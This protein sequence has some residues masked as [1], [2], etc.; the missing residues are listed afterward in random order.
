MAL[1]ASQDQLIAIHEANSIARLAAEVF[2]LIES[3]VV[4]SLV[5]VALRPLE[6]ELPCLSSKPEYKA[7]LDHYIEED[8]VFDLWLK[9]SPVHPRVIAVRHSDYTPHEMLLESQFYQRTLRPMGV[10]YGASLAIWRAKAWLATFTVFRHAG[11]GD[12]STEE[13]TLFKTWQPHIAS[14]V[15]RLA[16]QQ[17]EHLT[18]KSL[19][20]FAEHSPNGVIVLNWELSTL[21]CNKVARKLINRWSATLFN[22][23]AKGIRLPPDILEAIRALMPKIEGSKTNRP[24]TPH[25][26]DLQ[27]LLKQRDVRLM[28]KI[29]FVSAKALSISKG[30]FLIVISEMGEA[31]LPALPRFDKLS[32]REAECV[33]LVGLGMTNAQIALRTG[34]SPITVRNQLS[35]AFQKLGLKNR[36]ELAAAVIKSGQV[37]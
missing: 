26:L 1:S 31:S 23:N 5:F 34:T 33:K 28:A 7:V 32:A 20:V 36:Y 22:K 8:H 10:D 17:E 30:T 12:F 16:N 15:K 18:Q 9:R 35:A 24:S 27:A 14:A 29:T 37:S 3:Q 13:I 2:K 25:H 19:D 21:Y 4:C 11:Q 6:F